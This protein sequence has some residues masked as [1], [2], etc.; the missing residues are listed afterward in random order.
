LLSDTYGSAQA[1]LGN[2][3]PFL[4]ITLACI[5]SFSRVVAQEE[6]ISSEQSVQLHLIK[7]TLLKDEQ[8][9]KAWWWGWLAGYSAATAGQVAAGL[10]SDKLSV[11]Q[12]MYL[13]AATTLIGAAGQFFSP[14]SPPFKYSAFIDQLPDS[15]ENCQSQ[16]LIVAEEILRDY[17]QMETEGRSWEM[18]AISGAVN[19]GSGLITWFGFKRTWK[20]G[21]LNF[22]LNTAITEAQ[23]WSQPVLARKTYKRLALKNLQNSGSL[24][25]KKPQC[26]FCMKATANSF[27]FCLTF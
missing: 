13:G 1:I 22:T 20:D 7:N 26:S 4:L 19:L 2:P 5:I 16:K 25:F 23:I 9:R 27:G 12:D 14:V 15:I 11:R 3:K 10:G 8:K 18:H 6:I 21:L 17:A 24:N